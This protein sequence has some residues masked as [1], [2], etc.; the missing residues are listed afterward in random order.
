M[1]VS[2]PDHRPAL[3]ALLVVLLG[4]VL[5]LFTRPP[6]AKP[7]AGSAEVGFTQGMIQ[8]HAQ[9]IVMSRMI[10]ERSQNRSIRSFALD[11]DLAQQEEIRRMRGWLQMWN[12]PEGPPMKPEHARMMGM[13]SPAELNGL[14]TLP[15]REA[16]LS[17]LNLM[18]R[19]HEGALVMVKDVM[20]PGLHPEVQRL[21]SQIRV[22]QQGEIRTMQQLALR[23]GG[24]SP[25]PVQEGPDLEHHH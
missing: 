22:T 8:H 2:T 15:V 3:L 18:T 17:F 10:R 11:I 19:H 14:R 9:A 7:G 6:T 1:T 13:A 23:L 25:A 24:T 12:Q 16:E 4:A 20:K 5:F 21:A